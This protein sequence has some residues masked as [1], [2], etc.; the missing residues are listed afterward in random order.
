[1][2]KT[3]AGHRSTRYASVLASRFVSLDWECLDPSPHT[4]G[5]AWFTLIIRSAAMP[6]ST[7]LSS[8]SWMRKGIWWGA[9][10]DLEIVG[11]WYWIVNKIEDAGC[12]TLLAHAAKAKVMMGNVHKTDK[13]DAQG[14]ATLLYL[15]K[16]PSVW[17]PPASVRDERE[18]PRTRMTFA[19]HH[20]RVKSRIHST[21]A[22][23]ALSLNTA[24]DIF[25]PKWRAELKATLRKLPEETGRFVHQQLQILDALNDHI[26]QLEDRIMHRIHNIPTIQLVQTV[27]GPAKVLAI[28]IDREA[29]SIDRFPPAKHFASYCGL[30]PKLSAS[31]GRAHYGRMVKQCNTYLKWAFIEAANVIVRH[32]HHPNWRRKYVVQLYERTRRKGQAVAVGATARYLAEATYWVLKKSEPYQEPADWAPAGIKSPIS[33]SQGQARA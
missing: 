23:H 19:G 13:L 9:P 29:G 6:T 32:R 12:I 24:S 2:L 10:V 22:K 8:R 33:L 1:M 26:K 27:P 17:I 5:A 16:L 25:A 7:F 18:L 20:T 30:V 3:G 14:L 11:N 28:V 4:G 21:L 15:G 31:A